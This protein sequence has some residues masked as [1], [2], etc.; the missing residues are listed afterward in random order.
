MESVFIPHS[1]YLEHHGIK[2]QKWG[3][4]RYQ[5]L[6]GSY[7]DAGKK[8]YSRQLEKKVNKSRSNYVNNAFKVGTKMADAINKPNTSQV[9]N[10]IFSDPDYVKVNNRYMDSYSKHEHA[11]EEAVFKYGPDVNAMPEATRKKLETSA[12]NIRDLE[13]KHWQQFNKTINKYEPEL[14][15][16]ALKDIGEEDTELGRQLIKEIYTKKRKDQWWLT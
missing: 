15:S 2:G 6:D 12:N 10:K 3:L 14:L 16:A 9:R 8:R 4:R 13:K 7:T 11:L 1:D 5:N